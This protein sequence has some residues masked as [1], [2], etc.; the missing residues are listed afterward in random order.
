MRSSFGLLAFLFVIPFGIVTASA[1]SGKKTASV[2]KESTKPQYGSWGFDSAGAD[3]AKKP[4]DDF[5]TFASGAWLDRVQ[6]PADKSAYSLRLAMTDTTER[7]LHDL[8]EE[9]ARKAE[10][11]PAT[12]EGKVGAF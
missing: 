4:G 9:M 12:I 8:I 2:A 3:M 6:I 5:F 11:K 10:Q 1:E 7:R